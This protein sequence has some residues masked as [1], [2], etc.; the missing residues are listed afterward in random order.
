VAGSREAA[1]AMWHPSVATP[2]ADPTWLP[3]GRVLL[4]T[5]RITGMGT[6]IAGARMSA[7]ERKPHGPRPCIH[8]W[9]HR[10]VLLRHAMLLAAIGGLQ[11]FQSPPVMCATLN[12]K[13][14]G[15]NTPAFALRHDC[16]RGPCSRTRLILP[17]V[18][19]CGGPHGRR[20]HGLP[21]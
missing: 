10:S 11:G 18:R 6:N 5:P 1:R 14:C 16:A 13:A 15:R 19:S 3:T 20:R 17:P 7:G 21:W 12:G 8:S 2:A 4:K 9:S